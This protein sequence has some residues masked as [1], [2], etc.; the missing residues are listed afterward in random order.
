MNKDKIFPVPPDVK[1]SFRKFAEET[2]G[3]QVKDTDIKKI[4]V[5]IFSEHIKKRIVA[6]ICVGDELNTNVSCVYPEPILAIFESNA[7]LVITP[8]RGGLRGMPYL[9][10]NEEVLSVERGEK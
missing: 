5:S 3:W 7:Y 4:T 9:F 8:N 10:G 2:T 1:E 6:G